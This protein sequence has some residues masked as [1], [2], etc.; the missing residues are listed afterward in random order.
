MDIMSS[1]K[2][3]DV[4]ETL[5]LNLVIRCIVSSLSF[6]LSQESQVSKWIT[7][8]GQVARQTLR[9]SSSWP[10]IVQNTMDNPED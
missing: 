1:V 7:T 6:Y 5:I 10:P 2:R 3:S 8:T 9:H 4:R